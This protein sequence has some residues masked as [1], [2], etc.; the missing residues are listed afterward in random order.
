MTDRFRVAI[1]LATAFVLGAS[2]YGH[3]FDISP[4]GVLQDVWDGSD[5]MLYGLAVVS[6]FLV[7][8]WWALLPAIVPVALTIY[9]HSMTDYVSP[10]HEDE[11]LSVSPFFF[12]LVIG[13]I[14]I[15]AA[16]LSIGLLLRAAWE[17]ARSRRRR[18]TLPNSA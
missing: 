5:W 10:W 2:T 3:A 18:R 8:R 13:G 16:F 17:S 9:L 14:I 11:D 6:V 4:P 7:N 1:I 15:Q 12:L